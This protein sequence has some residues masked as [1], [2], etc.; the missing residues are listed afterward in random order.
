MR[1][2]IAIG[3]GLFLSF[4]AAY[5]SKALGRTT[6]SGAIAFIGAWLCFCVVDYWNGTKAGYSSLDELGIHIFVFTLPAIGAWLSAR[7]LG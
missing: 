4:A 5:I 3:I 1:T 6:V 7:I 2:L